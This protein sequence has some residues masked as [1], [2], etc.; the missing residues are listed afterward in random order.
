[1]IVASTRAANAGLMG[2]GTSWAGSGFGV[3]PSA[4]DV[5]R[6]TACLMAHVN[7]NGQ[8]VYVS[9][10]GDGLS[11]SNSEKGRPVCVAAFFS[12]T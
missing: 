6:V 3:K 12:R 5:E 11:S 10:R 1:M 8:K 9:F 4:A 2:L 7:A